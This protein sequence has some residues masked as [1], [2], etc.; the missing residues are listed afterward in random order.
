MDTL[1]LV[2]IFVIGVE[3]DLKKAYC[4]VVLNQPECLEE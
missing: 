2:A 1:R 4:R 3:H